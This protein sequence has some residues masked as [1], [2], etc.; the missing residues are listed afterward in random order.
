[1]LLLRAQRA[2]VALPIADNF[3]RPIN[4]LEAKAEALVNA[5]N[6]V[7]IMG[8]GIALQFKRAYPEVFRE[9]ERACKAGE[10]QPGTMHVFACGAGN[11]KFIINFPTKRHWR[12][13]S[14]MEDIESGLRALVAQVERLEIKSIALPALGC[15][16]GGLEWAEVRLRIEQAFARLPEVEVLLFAPEMFREV[17]T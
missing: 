7:G 12:D 13:N 1:M 17:A 16:L 14:R 15:G 10:V 11:P 2:G 5:V 4:L 3:R 8:K 9:Y 6:T